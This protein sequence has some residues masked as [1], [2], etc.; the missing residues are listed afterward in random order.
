M[1]ESLSCGE[2][3]A[4]FEGGREGERKRRQGRKERGEGDGEVVERIGEG[5]GG[6]E[7]G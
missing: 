2:E 4:S 1:V 7:K 3:V 6:R 5:I